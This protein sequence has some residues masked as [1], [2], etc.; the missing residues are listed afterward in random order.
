LQFAETE[1]IIEKKTSLKSNESL[2][3]DDGTA[4]I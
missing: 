1:L 3:I 4:T 2:L